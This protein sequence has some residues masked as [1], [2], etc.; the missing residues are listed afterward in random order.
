MTPA[1]YSGTPLATKL[2]LKPGM[3]MATPGAPDDFAALLDP[4]PATVEWLAMHEAAELQR[5]GILVDEE[6]AD[7]PLPLFPSTCSAL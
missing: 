1:G 4:L 6:G 2:G 5:M 7:R 3:R